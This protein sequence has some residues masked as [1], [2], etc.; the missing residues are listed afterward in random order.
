MHEVFLS[1][2]G[3]S[4]EGRRGVLHTEMELALALWAHAKF[5]LI[6]MFVDKGSRSHVTKAVGQEESKRHQGWIIKWCITTCG[7]H[8][9]T[10]CKKRILG[11]T[12]ERSERDHECPNSQSVNRC[13]NRCKQQR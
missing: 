4:F 11:R 8:P 6:R 1:T 10:S 7:H 13:V 9:R 3:W 2:S 5:G 12:V